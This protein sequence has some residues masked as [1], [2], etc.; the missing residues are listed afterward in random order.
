M[1]KR[2]PSDRLE[3]QAPFIQSLIEASSRPR[4]RQ[5]I[6]EHAN[7]DQI[8][9]VSDIVLNTLKNNVP[10]NPHLMAQLRHHK[11][12]LRDLGKHRNSFQHRRDVLLRQQGKG[13]WRGMHDLCSCVLP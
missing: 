3:R 11:K 5:Q 12:T 7:R 6:L 8:N 13:F 9:A 4:R 1:T 10:L 2:Y